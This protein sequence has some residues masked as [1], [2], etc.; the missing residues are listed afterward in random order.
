MRRAEQLE[1]LG[2]TCHACGEW[3]DD[4]HISVYKRRW[5]FANGGSVGEN[6]RYCNDRLECLEVVIAKPEYISDELR[7][8]AVRFWSAPNG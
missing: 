6:W 8:R 2:W 1:P 5:E 4:I 7:Y 3:R